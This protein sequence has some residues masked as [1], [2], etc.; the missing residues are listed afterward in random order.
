MLRKSV[1]PEV[2]KV[3]GAVPE[4]AQ[5]GPVPCLSSYRRKPPSIREV[6]C[7]TR[8]VMHV[9]GEHVLNFITDT[10]S[11]LDDGG[12]HATIRER[13]FLS[14]ALVDFPRPGSR[15]GDSPV[16][17]MTDRQWFLWERLRGQ[18]L[19]TARTSPRGDKAQPL[20]IPLTE[21]VA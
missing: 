9:E 13:R 11:I 6:S 12:P 14:Q 19:F 21:S 4:V 7:L 16:L 17:I 15:R 18:F 20:S 2:S 1:V 8:P 5:Q 10:T 3:R